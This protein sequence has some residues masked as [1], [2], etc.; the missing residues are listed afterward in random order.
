VP[1]GQAAG[2][3][4]SVFRSEFNDASVDRS[5]W[6]LCFAWGD[7]TNRG[8]HELQWYVEG[9]AV[10]R[11]SRLE[12]TVRSQPTDTP[13]GWLPYTSAMIQSRD[14]FSFT[15]GYAEARL[16]LPAGRGLW[17]AFWLLP[18]DLAWPPEIDIAEA[19]GGRPS[20]LTTAFHWS[21]PA[22]RSKA[23]TAMAQDLTAGWHVYGLEWSA[24]HLTWFLDGVPVRSF[25]DPGLV[26]AGPM[27]PLIN[28]A[29]DGSKPPD[30]SVTLPAALL[31]DYVRVYQR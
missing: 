22:G 15:Y 13:A 18:A 28:L 14:H 20:T 25:T 1:V 8:N 6:D 17:P 23:E 2:V 16:Q 31:V 24:D 4:R 12:L 10:V 9:N 5:Q 11:S 30:P 21:A 7:C 19:D 27:N 3:W 29:V 26:P